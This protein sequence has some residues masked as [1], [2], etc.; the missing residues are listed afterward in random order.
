VATQN[1][2]TMN[3]EAFWE[4][5]I[6]YTVPSKGIRLGVAPAGT[7][8]GQ[9]SFGADGTL[10]DGDAF[11]GSVDVSTLAPGDYEVFARACFASNCAVAS[12]PFTIA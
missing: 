4:E 1:G 2:G 11:E 3:D 5:G 7:P 8:A 6:A 9:V 12:A 10:G